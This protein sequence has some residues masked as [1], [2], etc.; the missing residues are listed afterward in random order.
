MVQ[1]T[2]TRTSE[3]SYWTY[4]VND[5]NC[6][7]FILDNLTTLEGGSVPSEISKFILQDVPSL[8]TGSKYVKLPA[9]ILTDLAG[10]WD[11][12]IGKGKKKRRYSRY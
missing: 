10:F 12:L 3:K 4:S 8:L 9:Q 2:I 11:R 1:E 6:Q 7:R 5:Y